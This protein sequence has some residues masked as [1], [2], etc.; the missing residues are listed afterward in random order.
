MILQ[1]GVIL[2]NRYEIMEK[3]GAGGMS[4]V[5]K[6]KCNKLQ[7]Y[8]AIKFLREEFITDEEFVTRFRIE[9]Q[10]AA[11][12]SHSNI[13]NIYD[14]GHEGDVHYIVMEYIQGKTLKE[15]IKE[16]GAF[17][18]EQVLKIAMAIA[19]A[20]QHAHRHH[21]VHRDIK[22]Q[23]VLV[24]EDGI[25]KVTDF[26][27]ARATTTSTVSATG[28][29]IGS[30]HYFSPEQARGGYVDQKSDLYSL[31]ITMYE[32]ATNSLPFQADSPV[33]VAL[34]HINEELPKPS[35]VN[36]HISKSL[37]G[38]IVKATQ[39]R[40]ELRYQNAEEMMIDMEKAFQYPESDFVTIRDMENSPTVQISSEEM[41]HIRA[42]SQPSASQEKTIYQKEEKDNIEDRQKEKWVTF[43]AVVTSFIIIAIISMFGIKMLKEYTKPT[44]VEV[45][46][47]LG[48]TIEEAE[49]LLTDQGLVLK[50]IGEKYNETVP[51]G[52]IISQYPEKSIVVAI[53]SFVEVE[54]SKGEELFEVPSVLDIEYTEAEK[55]IEIANLIPEVEPVYNESV[56][57]GII[58]DQR[59]AA[60][61]KLHRNEKVIIFAS[62]GKEET[63]VIVPDVRNLPEGEAKKRL[64]REKLQV[65]TITPVE[66]AQVEK[67]YVISQTV[68]H[69]QEV[70][71]GYIVDLVIST[72]KKEEK[73][74]TFSIT[75]P[76]IFSEEQA[77]GTI[78]V[79]METSS[80]R[81]KI[82]EEVHN[83]EDM[84]LTIPIQGTGRARIQI[85]LDS[86]LKSEGE[87][88]FDEVSE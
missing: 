8:V 53:G 19:K 18:T 3:I 80:A 20:L 50:K 21:I 27:I 48:R 14:V 39:K 65:G 77:E 54:V 56:P 84:P 76:D 49:Q 6:A 83:K 4:I 38:I 59:P 64:E 85:Y 37:E 41:R 63:M 17:P 73:P 88:V 32:M 75:I 72:G 10:A 29:T 25:V 28:N 78:V 31:G 16:K 12:L 46:D 35:S 58:F 13:V 36:P 66:S 45:I 70:R 47:I 33:S 5:Y 43:G 2:G 82:Y 87:I 51:E 62:L 81:T 60:G 22:P 67:G 23:N 24:T 26:G 74:K 44:H 1:P 52:K 40:P 30:V 42:H 79:I 86:A 55:K 15:W 11:S 71:E 34:L 57:L 69:G 68:P 61:T 9:A 7:R